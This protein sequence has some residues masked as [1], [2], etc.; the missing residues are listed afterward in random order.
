M[1]W[2]TKYANL[3]AYYKNQTNKQTNI[4][5]WPESTVHTYILEYV[6]QTFQGL[7]A[8]F[9]QFKGAVTFGIFHN[10]YLV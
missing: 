10:Y 6:T 4:Y 3:W 1:F 2:P 8:L 7:S 9:Q 5:Y